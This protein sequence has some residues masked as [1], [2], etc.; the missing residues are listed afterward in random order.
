MAEFGLSH[1]DIDADVDADGKAVVV[2]TG[3]KVGDS[4]VVKLGDAEIV[5]VGHDIVAI[6]EGVA[7]IL[8]LGVESMRCCDEAGV[9]VIF[10]DVEL[11]DTVILGWAVMT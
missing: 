8:S 4:D 6:K 2:K 7:G 1:V 10:M 5:I 3:V 11:L 9:L